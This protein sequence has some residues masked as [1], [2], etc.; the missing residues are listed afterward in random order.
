MALVRLGKMQLRWCHRCNLPVLEDDS[1]GLCRGPTREVL[2]TPP[3]DV[4]PAFD[5]DLELI[6]KV[7]DRQF[8]EGCGAAL[9]RDDKLSLM[10]KIPGLDRMDEVILDGEVA[11]TMRYDLGRGYTFVG[12]MGAA[13]AIQR[14]ISK[15]FVIASDD[16]V[17]FV[18][19]GL[20]LL[21]PGVKEADPSIIPGDEVVVLTEDHRAI[22]T[23]MAR[24][25]GKE[26]VSVE[27]GM[28][29]KAR[30]Q[31]AP[32]EI[33]LASQPRSWD[34]AV[35]ANRDVMVR[36]VEEAVGFIH[37]TREKYDLPSMVSFS[38]GK[39]SLACLLLTLD[40]GLRLPVFFVDTGLEFP[41]TVEH[42]HRVATKHGLQ[43]IEE[44]A[45]ADAFFGNLDYF[46]PPGR[47][48]RW[49]CKTNKL[50]PTVR[51]ILKHYPQGVLSFIGQR[52]YESEQRSEKPRVWRNPWTPGQVGASPIQDWTALHV[53]L[54]IFSK[55]EEYNP[56]YDWGLDRIGC[57][58]CPASDLA[59]LELVMGRSSRSSEWEAYLNRRAKE[60]GWTEDWLRYALWRWRRLPDAIRKELEGRGASIRR[61]MP[62]RGK[63]KEPVRL[64][65]QE[66]MSPCIMGYSVEGAFNREL[67]LKRV[68]NILCQL[69]EVEMDDQ[70]GWCKVLE[71]RIFDNGALVAKGRDPEQIRKNVEKVRRA[72]VKAEEC[73]GCGV[74]I[75]RCHEGALIMEQDRV[76]VETAKC[77]HCGICT[78]PCPAIS[79]GDASFEL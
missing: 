14:R 63:V 7:L 55:K 50:G 16:A 27:R 3:G 70:E 24:L 1:C 58:L 5:H 60:E 64:R 33:A 31:A 4:R 79:F 74:C 68:A 41:E 35:A 65:M 73:V 9:L 52:R 11:G 54:Y 67:D 69:G 22:C 71:V 21:A 75:A 39:D 29:V 19:Q 23:G 8:G 34:D 40:A 59:E 12:R 2:I 48:F 13:R 51:A 45:P 38:G 10:N 26:M 57:F 36:R 17:P 42:V 20:N 6:K 15:G 66:G 62:E 56:W 53:W 77:I 46:G 61:S 18:L 44:A 32:Q 28:A 49:C 72:V 76:L 25:G 47:D 30:W 43:L 78:E 37:R